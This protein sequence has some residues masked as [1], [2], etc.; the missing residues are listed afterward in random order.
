MDS[1]SSVGESHAVDIEGIGREGE[2]ALGCVF[3]GLDSTST[4][5]VGEGDERSFGCIIRIEGDL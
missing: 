5:T 4:H 3:S 1:G 2:D